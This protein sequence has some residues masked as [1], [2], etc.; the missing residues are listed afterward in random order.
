MQ[1][2]EGGQKLTRSAADPARP[3]SMPFRGGNLPAR[4]ASMAEFASWLER[5]V[6]D[7]PAID[8]TG[9]EG[10]WDFVLTWTRE[11]NDPRRLSESHLEGPADLFTA[12]QKQLGLKLVATKATVDVIIVDH[13]EKPTAN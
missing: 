10:K 5:A 3:W 13:V 9:L 8:Q 11:G 1:I 7:R 6:L 12:M 4:N 2:G